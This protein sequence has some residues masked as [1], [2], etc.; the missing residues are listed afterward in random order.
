MPNRITRH[1]ASAALELLPDGVLI[2]RLAGPL[3][4]DALLYFKAQIVARHGPDIRAFVAD[5][6]GAIIAMDGADLDAV[7]DGE[8]ESAPGLP[9]A[10]ICRP[11]SNGLFK[12]HA[13]RMA[14]HHGITRRVFNSAGPA[15][16]WAQEAARRLSP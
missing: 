8:A 6:T 1:S 3:T 13:L 4:G 9:A 12:G 16:A 15:L 14:G 10:I 2:V 7:L 11:E 5:Y